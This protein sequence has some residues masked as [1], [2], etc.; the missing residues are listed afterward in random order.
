MNQEES[1]IDSIVLVVSQLDVHYYN[2]LKTMQGQQ[3]GN[4]FSEA[5]PVYSNIVN[6]L[7]ILGSTRKQVFKIPLGNIQ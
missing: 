6:G 4:P 7:G 5:D 2:F 1:V 3:Y